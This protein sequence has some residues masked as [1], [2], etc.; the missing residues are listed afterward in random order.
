M[1]IAE[2]SV[3]NIFCLLVREARAVVNCEMFEVSWLIFLSREASCL[4]GNEKNGL[5]L[6]SGSRV[7]LVNI[8]AF[9][10]TGFLESIF[11]K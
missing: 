7:K 1:V 11:L 6:S 5:F 10:D 2:R 8:G 4:L 3:L 9:L